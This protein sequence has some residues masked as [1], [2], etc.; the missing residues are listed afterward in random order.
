MNLKKSE[1]ILVSMKIAYRLFSPVIII[2]IISTSIILHHACGK[3]DWDNPY[4]SNNNLSDWGPYDLY[5]ME[6]GVNKILL[7]WHCDVTQIDGFKIDKKEGD[8][9][10][11]EG[12]AETGKNFMSFIDSGNFIPGN[13]YHYRVAAFYGGGLSDY[14]ENNVIIFI[15]GVSFTDHRNGLSYKTT[16]IGEQCWMAENLNSVAGNSWCYENNAIY[17]DSLGRLYDWQTLMSG[18][19]SSNSVPSGVQGICPPGWHVPSHAEWKILE[20]Y[21]DSHYSLGDPEWDQTGF[22]G[23]DAGKKLKAESGWNYLGNGTNEYGFSA[24]PGGYRNDN[25]YY[26]GYIGFNGLFWSS[27]E[28]NSAEAWYRD[29][30]NDRDEIR[31]NYLGKGYGLSARC[32][33]D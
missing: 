5:V 19:S 20:G 29:F 25:G 28:S 23:F 2:F 33:K 27:T 6:T 26:G 15:C 18:T 10:W 31:S 3:K 8:S 30:Q 13:I 17:C 21:V 4:D 32:L 12:Y 1:L 22:R 24:L 14:A 16:L 11:N 7:T 9:A